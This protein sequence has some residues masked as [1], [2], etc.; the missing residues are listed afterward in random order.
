MAL[1]DIKNSATITKLGLYECNVMP[2]G[3][4]NV[5]GI[6]S[7]I[8]VEIFKD[9]SNKFLKVF[10]DDVN[11]HSLN[12]KDHLQ[13][14]WMVL[15]RLKEVHLKLNPNK[16][17]FKAQNITF[18]GH[19]MSIKRSYLD[20]KKIANVESSPITT[21]VTNVRVVLGLIRYYR[22]FIFGYARIVE[23]FLGLTKKDWNFVWPPF[24]QGEFVILKRCLVASP[25]LTWPNFSQ[26]FIFDINWS[27]RGVGAIVSQNLRN[28]NKLS[29]MLAK[30]CFLPKNVPILLKANVMPSYGA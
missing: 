12:W 27:I 17:C 24:C 20:L 7:W 11:I 3:L 19:V 13:H 26:P 14:I 21:I 9:W 28:K 18:L 8:M 25:I 4:K 10:V 1:E 2:F 16:C 23:P 15:Q 22:K 5:I 29:P 6:F 30:D